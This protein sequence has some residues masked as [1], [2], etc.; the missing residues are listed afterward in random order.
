[1]LRRFIVCGLLSVIGCAR[2]ER[3]TAD[4]IPLPS[5]QPTV[6]LGEVSP[7]QAEPSAALTVATP[8]RLVTASAVAQVEPKRLNSTTM[9]STTKPATSAPPHL[10]VASKRC[11]SPPP[12]CAGAIGFCS[13]WDCVD[14]K[15]VS[16]PRPNRATCAGTIEACRGPKSK[17]GDLL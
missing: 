8:E 5:A 17:A 11:E 2:E 13:S 6:L 15:W 9:L 16:K 12:A 4:L 14:G 7:A 1:M 3:V 10:P